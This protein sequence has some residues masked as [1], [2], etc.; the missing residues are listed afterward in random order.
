[1]SSSTVTYTLISSDYEEPSDT[2]S[3]GVVVYGYDGLPMHLVD[4]YVEAAL[5]A[6]EQAPPSPYYVL[7]PEH[8]P[9]PDYDPEEDLGDYPA[10]GGD[11]DD[12]ESSDDDD[13]DV[14]EDKE[15]EE[16]HL[17][18][19]DSSDV[20]AIDP[21]P[22]AEDTEAFETDESAPTPVPSP[23]RRTA[24]MS[25]RPQILMLNTLEAL[26]AEFP[27][28]PYHYHHY[29]LLAPTYV[30]GPL[31]YRAVGIRLRAALPPT[32]HPSEIP[33]PPLLLPSTTHRDDL[34]EVNMPL[35]KRAHFTAPTGRFEVEESSSTAAARQA[36]H[37]LTHT[38]D[39]GFI[40]TMDASIRA[41]ESRA[42]TA[43]RVVN[44]RVT[45]LATTQR[46]DAQELYMRCGDA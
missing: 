16:E 20:P 31:G 9:S 43:V 44:D 37:T 46:Q 13:N 25:I 29:L 11:D 12:D 14:E 23:R 24:R 5:Q 18:P 6:P 41:A 26:I 17:A 34:P 35:Q 2:C 33:S 4:P 36:G 38:V 39:Y 27:H 32:Y 40:D 7:G 45:D 15:E 30:E 3:P 21:V 19:T 8:L 1:M 10:D 28:H 22:S 42:M